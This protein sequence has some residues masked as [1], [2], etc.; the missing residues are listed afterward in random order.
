MNIRG[1][2]QNILPGVLFL[3]CGT[4]LLDLFAFVI[5]EI[6]AAEN[7]IML[8]DRETAAATSDPF[9]WTSFRTK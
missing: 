8:G 4:A 2:P 1:F 9:L 6:R 3:S 5:K 7:I